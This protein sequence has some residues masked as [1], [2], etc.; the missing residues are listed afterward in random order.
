MAFRL[1]LLLAL[2]LALT[3]LWL[4]HLLTLS[5][6]RNDTVARPTKLAYGIES[7][8]CPEVRVVVFCSPVDPQ[9]HAAREKAIRIALGTGD[10]YRSSSGDCLRLGVT[11]ST[12]PQPAIE[13]TSEW[14]RAFLAELS[15]HAGLAWLMK[16]ED[17]T[18]LMPDRLAELLGG[19]DAREPLILGNRLQTAWPPHHEYV[20]GAGFVISAAM[21]KRIRDAGGV[22]LVPPALLKV[23]DIGFS[24]ICRSLGGRMPDTRDISGG[25]RFNVFPPHVSALGAYH[26]WYVGY[27]RQAGQPP[28]SGAACCAADSVLFQYVGAN[29]QFSLPD[30]LRANLE[31]ISVWHWPRPA[32]F[33]RWGP[34]PL[35]GVGAEVSLLR[36]LQGF[37]RSGTGAGSVMQQQVVHGAY[38]VHA[39]VRAGITP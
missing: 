25:E 20:S 28:L 14:L 34:L 21:L 37:N 36:K 22:A 8:F 2:P 16:V 1:R 11:F 19:L 15:S 31:G 12:V 39:E 9:D 10:L 38:N 5:P 17:T 27:K 6:I 18:W 35:D 3:G 30:A 29:E 33:D 4:Y 7:T 32:L 24:L 26:D 23:P 13:D